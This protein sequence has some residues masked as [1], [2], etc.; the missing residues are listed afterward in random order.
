MKKLLIIILIIIGLNNTYASWLAEE[1]II[2]TCTET[3][4]INDRIDELIEINKKLQEEN[5]WLSEKYIE[6][7]KPLENYIKILSEIKTLNEGKSKSYDEII[8]G[9]SFWLTIWGSFFTGIVL[10]LTWLWYKSGMDII[11]KI[12]LVRLEKELDD[13]KIWKQFDE[14]MVKLE[15]NIKETTEWR[16]IWAKMNS[17]IDSETKL[18]IKKLIKDKKLEIKNYEKEIEDINLKIK[19]IEELI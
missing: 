7:N 17:T 15:K 18:E 6:F 14:Y 2:N 5:K 3:K 13:E 12:I 11:E 16:K 19:K 1:N 8:N 4:C 9:V 10:A